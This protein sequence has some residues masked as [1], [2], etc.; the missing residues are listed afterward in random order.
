MNKINFK[1]KKLL[2]VILIQGLIFSFTSASAEESACGTKSGYHG[3][4]SGCITNKSLL[5][6][7]GISAKSLA[8]QLAEYSYDEKK[9]M[10]RCGIFGNGQADWYVEEASSNFARFTVMCSGSPTADFS[11]NITSRGGSQYLSVNVR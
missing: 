3:T 1:M 8:Q 2:Q 10:M 5:S 7:A 11:V 9:S 6:R 4:S